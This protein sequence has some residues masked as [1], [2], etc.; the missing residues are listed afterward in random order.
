MTYHLRNS[1]TRKRSPASSTAAQLAKIMTLFTLPSGLV[2]PLLDPQHLK[3]SDHSGMLDFL[4]VGGSLDFT[5]TMG[6]L[7]I[8]TGVTDPTCN[9]PAGVTSYEKNGGVPG[10]KAWAITRTDGV[11]MAVVVTGDTGVTSCELQKWAAKV[12]WSKAPATTDYFLTYNVLP[13]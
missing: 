2:N 9:I 1:S 5:K 8:S 4:N 12:D 6:G 7:V 10:V 13:Y 11:T 3:A